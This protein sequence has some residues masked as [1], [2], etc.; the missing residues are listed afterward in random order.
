[1]RT[2]EIFTLTLLTFGSSLPAQQAPTPATRVARAVDSAVYWAHERF[3]ADDALEGRAPATRGGLLAAK[4]IAAQFARLGLLPA[5]DSGTYLHR[6][7]VIS[8]TPS[9]DLRVLRPEPHTL[10]Y[11]D[12]YVMWSMRNDSM[13]NLEADVVFAGYGIVAPEW[14]WND[15]AGL[16]AHGKIVVVLVNDP[17]LRDSTIFRGK[18]LTYYGRWTYKIEEAERQGA[19]GILFVHTPESATYGWST[20]A[21]SWTG[22]Q[23]ALEEPATS[24]IVAGWL[25]EK[26]ASDL[27]RQG[28]G[29]LTRWTAEAGRKGF[30][31]RP[32]SLHLAATVRSA[33]RRSET[34]NVVAR[35]PGQ[36]PRAA[37]AV[38]IGG[39]Y[40]HLGI[41]EPVNGDSIYNGAEDNASGTAAVLTMAEAFVRSGVRPAR[42]ILFIAFG[43]EESG[44]LGSQAFADRPTLPLRNLVAVLNVDVM[45]FY[46]RTSDIAALGTDQSSLGGVFRQAASAEGLRLTE[47]EEALLQGSFFRSDHFPFARAG[48]PALSLESGNDYVGRPAGWGAAEHQRYTDERYHQPG[49]EILPWFT[50]AGVV[51]QMR[52][53]VWTAMAVANAASPP[54]WNPTSEF[55]AAGEARVR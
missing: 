5:G 21:G 54:T 6:V 37:E 8:L 28:G 19:A 25:S 53:I 45:N 32:L 43:A 18:I 4:Y 49:D 48:V 40:D 15:Y 47:N 7:P 17:G 46:G 51:Q 10:A 38:L 9:P 26:T 11:R 27:F 34:S 23:V 36:G 12:D 2:P 33:V 31:A 3:L 16:D 20:V 24:L 29:D 52:V 39:H 14:G 44:L 55:R 1:M 50:S 30:Q 41:R 22:P 35:L 42:S 13:V